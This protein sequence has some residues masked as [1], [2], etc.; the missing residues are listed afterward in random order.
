M[1]STW[2]A[3]GE[4][5]GRLF[6]EF[7]RSAWRWEC[8]GVYH[9]PAEVQPW[10]QWRDGNRDDAWLRPWADTIRGWH[11][12]GKTFERVRMLTEPLTEYLRW[13]LDFTY[14]NVEAGEDI[15]WI[16]QHRARELGAPDYDFYLFDDA[17]VAIMHFDEHGVSGADLI[18]DPD[19]VRQHQRWRDLVWP[20]AIR[21]NDY[22]AQSPRGACDSPG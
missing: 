12:E 1:T 22:L 17:R 11:G 9:E 6:S 3:R 8:Q 13:M 7:Q 21:H 5:F 15:R 4:P 2:I 10:Q 19:V 18:D 16:E 20:L 14:V